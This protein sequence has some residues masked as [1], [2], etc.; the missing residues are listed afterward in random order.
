MK[1]PALA[2][3]DPSSSEINTLIKNR[4]LSTSGQP[5]PVDG[6]KMVEQRD[7]ED[8]DE[9]RCQR[10]SFNIPSMMITDECSIGRLTIDMLSDDVLLYIFDLYR[11]ELKDVHNIWPWHALIHVCQRWRHVI[12]AWPHHLD[13]QLD[14]RSGIGVAKALDI[15]PANLLINIRSD[16]DLENG[17]DIVAALGHRDRI[18]GIEMTC[19]T[20]L[21]LERCTAVMQEPFPLLRTLSFRY[22][23]NDHGAPVVLG[24]FLGGSAPR[25]QKITLWCVPFP[26]LPELLLSTKDLVELNLDKITSAG[27][28]SPDALATS[29]SMLKGLEHIGV[30]FQSFKS[31]P[32]LTNRPP[33]PLIRAVL[34]A[35]KTFVFRGI[36]KY[37]EDLIARIDAPLLLYFSLQ[38][39][40][41]PIFDIPQVPQFLCCV[42]KFKS[43][44]TADIDF[45]KYTIVVS[46]FSLGCNF[47]LRF[48]CTGFNEQLLLL[49][50]ICTQF[51]PHTTHVHHL[52]LNRE[53]TFGPGREDSALWLGFFRPFN[54]V[55]VLD[56]IGD[57]LGVDIACVLGGLTAGRAAEALPMLH[58]VVLH[59]PEQTNPL[60][61]RLSRLFIDARK[62]SDHPV[63]ISW[64][65][66]LMRS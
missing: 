55:Q 56:V 66:Q 47:F 33:P 57:K 22:F 40:Y 19:T 64:I 42:E 8:S 41:Q 9:G 21:Q 10:T 65:P 63:A 60:V 62:L 6:P 18:A 14:C 58:T 7:K 20:M 46:L 52:K 50:Q 11:Q 31:F 3:H 23:K 17:D 15:W 5:D 48:H 35:L 28:I 44:L 27:Y 59:G 32:S 43:P 38:F 13:L 54:A 34:P 24:A 51:F 2:A 16:L 26:T 4:L 12:F 1:P 39:F 36:S 61:T 29:L 37:S 49:K 30:S 53:Y 45:F 25:L